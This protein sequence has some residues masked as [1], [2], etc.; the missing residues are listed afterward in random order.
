[1]SYAVTVYVY[2][3][4]DDCEAWEEFTH[5]NAGGMNKTT[6]GLL[7]SRTKGWWVRGGNDPTRAYCPEHRER[8]AAAALE[9]AVG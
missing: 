5:Q 7:A 3:D 8:E 6:A 1:M 9:R 4:A 2:C